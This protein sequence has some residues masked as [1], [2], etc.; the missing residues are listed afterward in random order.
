M[1]FCYYNMFLNGVKETYILQMSIGNPNELPILW[2][3]V[4]ECFLP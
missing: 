2:L 3:L 1:E 4:D